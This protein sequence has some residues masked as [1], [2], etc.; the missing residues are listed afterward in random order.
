MGHLE[1]QV[2][3]GPRVP[4][5]EAWKRCREYYVEHFVSSQLAVDSQVFGI[6]DPYSG[7][8]IPMVNVIA[9]FRGGGDERGLLFMAHWDSRPR[10]DFPTD[11]ALAD[12]PIP[13]A[14]DGA[15]GAA[16]LLELATLFH[17]VPPKANIDLVLVDGEDWGR[18]GDE[19]YYL[20]G[21]RE[22][23]SHDVRDR[24]QF[25]IV[26]DMIGDVDLTIYR[27]KLSERFVKKINDY[28]WQ[29]AARLSLPAFIDSVKHSVLDDHI[30]LNVGGIPAIDII[31]FDY[32]YWHS[33]LDTSDKC[34]AASLAQVGR[35]LIEIA[36]HPSTW[37]K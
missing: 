8:S 31:D 22:F 26:I 21:S 14:N 30:A 15:S 11:P 10:T 12:Q 37:P 4:G 27:E 32:P 6:V 18:S 7:D 28:V 9:S 5:S 34:S 36:Y 29:T 35:L 13:G 19:D 33:N 16:V 20:L 2:A 3:F 24:Y 1:T 23:A 17:E 25:G